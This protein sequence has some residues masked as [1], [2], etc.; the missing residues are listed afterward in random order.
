MVK[1]ENCSLEMPFLSKEKLEGK[2][3]FEKVDKENIREKTLKTYIDFTRLHS[4]VT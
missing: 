2:E 1:E 3:S 4:C